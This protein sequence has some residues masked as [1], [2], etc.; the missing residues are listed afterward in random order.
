MITIN[1][2]QIK[3]PVAIINADRQNRFIDEFESVSGVYNVDVV[4]LNYTNT[5][6]KILDMGYLTKADFEAIRPFFYTQQ[7][8]I[9][10]LTDHEFNY[11]NAFVKP[12][13]TFVERWVGAKIG[14]TLEIIPF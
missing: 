7:P 2:T 5:L 12:S 13:S 4:L 8:V 11:A 3:T 14:L 1:G 6:T 10:T 9:S